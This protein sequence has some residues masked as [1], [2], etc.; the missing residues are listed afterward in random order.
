MKR[1]NVILCLALALTLAI[2][3][4]AQSAMW[5][6]AQLGAN[7]AANTDLDAN[8]V[9]TGWAAG[10]FSYNASFKNAKVEPSVIGGLILGYD[11]VREGFLGYNWPDWMKYFSFATDFTFNR[12]DM[13][14]QYLSSTLGVHF[15]GGGGFNLS[16]IARAGRTE[17]TMAVWSFLFIGKYGFF[18][19]SEVPFGRVVPYIGVGPG[20]VFSSIENGTLT[21][22]KNGDSSVDIALVV[23]SGI[24]FMALKNVSLDVAFRYRW[25]QPSYNI[26]GNEPYFGGF[27]VT[28]KASIDANQFSAIARA[29][30]HF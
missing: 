11:F 30:Y 2:A 4:T 9:S 18:P 5:V 19:D 6:G 28:A 20:I 10:L 15:G 29:N 3:G 1:T 16:G 22:G 7:F 14:E 12:F 13:R 27:P 17:G 26:N 25:C 24:R 21:G 8:G 23:E